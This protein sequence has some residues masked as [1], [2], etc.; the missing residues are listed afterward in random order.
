M[1][2]LVCV[3]LKSKSERM[4]MKR[5]TCDALASTANCGATDVSQA[6]RRGGRLGLV[7]RLFG[8]AKDRHL[9]FRPRAAARSMGPRA[10]LVRQA[11]WRRPK[12]LLKV[13]AE[14]GAPVC[15]CPGIP[16]FQIAR[17]LSE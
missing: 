12:Q 15:G 10:S 14:M 13:Y 4:A 7:Y 8:C 9:L 2:G 17:S 1:E 11:F 3:A 16:G 6:T 5:G